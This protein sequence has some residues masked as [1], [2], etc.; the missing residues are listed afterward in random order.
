MCTGCCCYTWCLR[1]W[2]RAQ[3]TATS[4]MCGLTSKH[5]QPGKTDHIPFAVNWNTQMTATP[6]SRLNSFFDCAACQW[7]FDNT[8]GWFNTKIIE[9][10]IIPRHSSW[11]TGRCPGWRAA[12][13]HSL[14][15]RATALLFHDPCRL[16]LSSLCIAYSNPVVLW[17]LLL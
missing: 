14:H 6:G 12:V 4:L 16:C 13:P 10:C 11:S 17:Q 9:F 3:V 2:T 8:L 15:D 7:S 5:L 1:Y